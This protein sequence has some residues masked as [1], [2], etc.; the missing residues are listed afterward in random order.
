MK[1]DLISQFIDDE[2]AIDDKIELIE[3][4]HDSTDFKNETIYYLEQEKL[5]QDD[6]V[7]QMPPVKLMPEPKASPPWFSYM[8][9]PL[10]GFATVLIIAAAVVVWNR[11]LPVPETDNFH[12]F[13]IYRPAAS[14]AQVMGTFTGWQALPMEKIGSTGYWTLT[15]KIAPGEHR[16]SFLVENGEKIGDPTVVMRERD[17]FGGINSILKVGAQT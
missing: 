10:F 11:P 2:M 14:Q 9:K 17:D 1:E 8:L 13:V 7:V 6:M 4:V 3:S 16:Y 15:L 5:I 12:R